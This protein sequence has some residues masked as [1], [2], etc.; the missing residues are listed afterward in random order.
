MIELRA[1]HGD[2]FGGKPG[3]NVAGLKGAVRK[4]SLLFLF[5]GV[6]LVAIVLVLMPS[7]LPGLGW[8]FRVFYDAGRAYLHGRSPYPDATLAGVVAKN[9]FVYPAPA[10]LALAPFAL[11]PYWLAFGIWTL[12]FA[13]AVS[14]S[15][16]LMNVRD[17]RC[18]GAV[19]LSLPLLSSLRLGTLDALLLL[20]LAVLW[21]CRD[22]R[23]LAMAAGA[24]LI[25]LKIFLWPLLIWL[26]CTRRSKTAVAAAATAVLVSAVAWLPL[27]F[28]NARHYPDVLN[29]LAGYERTFSLSPTS[30]FLALGARPLSAGVV[31][32]LVGAALV[33]L[34]WRVGRSDDGLSFRLAIACAF[35]LSPIVW[36]HYWMLLL[37]P[38]ALVKPGLSP[39][40]FAA[41]WIPA[42]A[43]FWTRGASF[44]TGIALLSA[45]LQ[46][47]LFGRPVVPLALK[48][49]RGRR[50]G[51]IIVAAALA[52]VAVAAVEAGDFSALR[53]AILRS[54][55]GTA[56][57]LT[58]ISLDVNAR[59]ICTF[60]WT[61]GTRLPKTGRIAFGVGA[62]VVLRLPRIRFR[63]DGT[64]RAC[65]TF[66][67]TEEP[68]IRALVDGRMP[69][70]VTISGSKWASL[71]GPLRRAPR[72]GS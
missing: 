48:G 28:S 50:L 13:A 61:D 44:W 43:L 69:Y 12:C 3:I 57:A 54:A 21:R 60:T 58:R 40:W 59:S 63:P 55:D 25:V 65:S 33:L 71:V 7:L 8:D 34:I 2:G 41:S 52:C 64:A 45:L 14:A 18:Y 4:I 67:I 47:G 66:P 31:I 6:P 62:R 35:W 16:W 53:G 38:I 15:L 19:F 1:Q 22:R 20:L 11:L 30:L 70:S 10:A 32:Y 9:V 26:I 37:V 36:G 17:W 23:V 49:D 27:G 72:P 5:A 42:D 46:L 68:A 39:R 24:G 56:F 51:T 29:S